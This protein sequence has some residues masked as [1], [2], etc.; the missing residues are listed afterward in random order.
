MPVVS[1]VK[2]KVGYWNKKLVQAFCKFEFK[3]NF[4]V[5]SPIAKTKDWV[6]LESYFKSYNWSCMLVV[7]VL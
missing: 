4:K 1:S 6:Q 2:V 3:F 5:Q 7:G